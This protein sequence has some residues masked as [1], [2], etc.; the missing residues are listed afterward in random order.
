MG[1]VITFAVGYLVG[2]QTDHEQFDDLVR[3]VRALR[4]SEEFAGVVMAARSHLSHS[5]R[6]A[7]DMVDGRRRSAEV[8]RTAGDE[9]PDLVARV[10]DLFAT[11]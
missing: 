9:E 4:E 10:R 7:A 5:L 6:A 3:A 2:L 11:D 8:G 1:T